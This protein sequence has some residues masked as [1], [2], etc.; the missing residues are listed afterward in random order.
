VVLI[1][2]A[3]A[4]A[5]GCGGGGDERRAACEG[6]PDFTHE[7]TYRARAHGATVVSPAALDATVKAI[8]DRAR[9][10][11]T[12]DVY[13]E[14]DGAGQIK[15]GGPQ[16]PSQVLTA[17]ARL[18]FYD[19][20]PNL[21]PP[22]QIQ[23]TLRLFD[24][25]RS[26]SRQK[27]RSEAVDKPDDRGNDTAGVKYYVFGR[28][29]QP[30]PPAVRGANA[31]AAYFGS[32]SEIA[33]AFS[34]TGGP[35]AGGPCKALR[36]LPR[37]AVVVAVPRGVVLLGDE[38]HGPG[39]PSLGYW[40]LEDDAELTSPDIEEPKQQ[41]D[42]QTN[43]PIVTFQFSDRGRA[44]FARVTKRE[45]V[46]GAQ[47]PHAPGAPV[48]E[49]FQKFAIALDGQLVSLATIDYQENPEGIAGDTGAQINGLGN[50]RETQ[51]LA[52]NL[53]TRPLPL[54]LV[55]VKSR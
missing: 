31:A 43:E 29:G 18:A 15:V 37:G 34:G 23:P 5:S 9:R 11:G 50:L 24:A 8:C 39:K 48:Q 17:G 3:A 45:A 49:T 35:T 2:I 12:T 27:P 6:K 41:F 52:R 7:V 30:L 14:R 26:A 25:A 36:G 54:D 13:V 47:I 38:P 4:V 1:A 51:E 53:A 42:P 32:C 44:A 46:R 22:K 40:T 55:P 33:D 28:D 20:E 10:A 21:L 16:P 19:W